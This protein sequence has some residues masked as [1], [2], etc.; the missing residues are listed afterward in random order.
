MAATAHLVV[1]HRLLLQIL[2]VESRAVALEILQVQIQHHSNCLQ[3]SHSSAQ[4]LVDHSVLG[5]QL[6]MLL[7]HSQTLPASLVS[8]KYIRDAPQILRVSTNPNLM[9]NLYEIVHPLL[10]IEP[11]ASSLKVLDLVHVAR[12]APLL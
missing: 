4:L 5:C 2:L 6:V 3:H 12:V 1:L 7:Q 8:S 9:A 10:V 11:D